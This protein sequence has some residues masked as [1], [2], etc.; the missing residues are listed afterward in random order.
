[1]SKNKT[2]LTFENS[3][4]AYCVFRGYERVAEMIGSESAKLGPLFAAAPELLDALKMMLFY[5]EAFRDKSPIGT[6]EADD[7]ATARAAIAKA[8]GE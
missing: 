1:M 4:M 5:H 6:T 2:P 3:G 8:K 7:I